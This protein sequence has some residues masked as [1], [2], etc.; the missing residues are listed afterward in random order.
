MNAAV[1]TNAFGSISQTKDSSASSI[2]L[3]NFPTTASKSTNTQL[4]FT[5]QNIFNPTSVK[6][7]TIIVSF[8][9]VGSLYQ[10][11]TIEYKAVTGTA[12][13][14]QLRPSDGFVNA[15]GNCQMEIQTNL[16]IPT[17][18]KLKISYP[19][20]VSVADSSS[21]NTNSA[22]LNGISVSGSTFVTFSNTIIFT[23]VFQT[24]FT[25]GTLLIDFP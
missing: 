5:L 14:F 21:L 20:T 3:S 24:N 2:T 9:R 1:S 11:S 18:S 12:T 7:I 17:G 10:Q 22:L 25:N 15:K 13:F 6:P 8:Y 23:N 19:A 16:M 4:N